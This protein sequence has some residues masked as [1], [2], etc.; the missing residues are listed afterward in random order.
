MLIVSMSYGSTARQFCLRHASSRSSDIKILQ[1]ASSP[2]SA[3]N[4]PDSRIFPEKDL[5]IFG[6]SN[7]CRRHHRADPNCATLHRTIDYLSVHLR[8][9][10]VWAFD[11][12]RP[13]NLYHRVKS[14]SSELSN[15]VHPLYA[16]TNIRVRHRVIPTLGCAL[17]RRTKRTTK[18]RKNGKRVCFPFSWSGINNVYHL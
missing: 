16:H 6:Y 15:L 8:H 9:Q 4:T 14:A 5:R 10:R 17:L 3:H 1:P 7:R 11:S 2:F 13:E 18:Y 12:T